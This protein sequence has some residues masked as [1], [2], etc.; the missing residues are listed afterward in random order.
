MSTLDK[1]PPE[2]QERIKEL[3]IKRRNLKAMDGKSKEHQEIIK[4][5]RDIVSKIDLMTKA[6]E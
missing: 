2:L 6:K 4:I 1:F 5:L 3:E